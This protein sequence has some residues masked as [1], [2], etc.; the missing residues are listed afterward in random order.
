MWRFLLT[1]LGD[2]FS[3]ADWLIKSHVIT[4]E[5]ATE[6]VRIGA[7]EPNFFSEGRRAVGGG[8]ADL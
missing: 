7:R 5:S 1:F 4:Q 6:C 8:G 2:G 3:K